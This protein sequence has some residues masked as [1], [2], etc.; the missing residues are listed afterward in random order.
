MKAL[1]KLLPIMKELFLILDAVES[2]S[3]D[4]EHYAF[5]G[6]MKELGQALKLLVMVAKPENRKNYLSNVRFTGLGRALDKETSN[7][8][9]LVAGAA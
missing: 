1:M 3:Q 9:A 5:S 8:Q 7:A 6:E 4:P 2:R